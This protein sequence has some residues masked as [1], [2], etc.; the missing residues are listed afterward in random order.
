MLILCKKIMDK[1]WIR[2]IADLTNY[3]DGQMYIPDFFLYCIAI[4]NFGN[5]ILNL[6]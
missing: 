5:L 3:S 1:I 2:S 6:I 4:H